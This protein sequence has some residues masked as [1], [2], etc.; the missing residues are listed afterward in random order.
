VWDDEGG[1]AFY[2][3]TTLASG[4]EL[5]A[6]VTTGY[7]PEAFVINGR[8]S[9]FPYRLMA[10]YY[11]RGAMGYGMGKLEVLEHDGQ[12]NIAFSEHPFVVMKDDAWVDLTLLRHRLLRGAREQVPGTRSE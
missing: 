2:G 6:D 7:G 5:T 3:A 4:G 9:G 12:G 11:A 10:H 8:K 1:H